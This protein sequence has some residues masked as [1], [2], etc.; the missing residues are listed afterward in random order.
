MKLVQR[1]FLK[2]SREFEI[3]DDVVLVRMKAAFKEEKLTVLLTMLDPE[4]VVN[5]PYLEFHSRVKCGPL[6]SLLLDKP[7]TEAFNA[8]VNTLKQRAR[9]EYN[10]FAGLKAGS[11]PERLAGNVYT[12]PP[13]F[14]DSGKNKK[15]KKQ[16]PVDVENLPLLSRCFTSIWKPKRSNRCS[17]RW[18]H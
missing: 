1:Q 10:A 18:K 17:L 13:N 4:P 16:K 11:Q 3:I 7:N 8:F 2:G 15:G 5:K 9:E 14:D 12:E 6:L